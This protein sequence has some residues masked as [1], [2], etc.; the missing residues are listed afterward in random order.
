MLKQ[1]QCAIL[2]TGAVC[3][4][5]AAITSA[6]FIP[7]TTITPTAWF[8]VDSIAASNPSI[9]DGASVGSWAD[10]S[11]NG[12]TA[13]SAANRNPAYYA[14]QVNGHGSVRFNYLAPGT[15]QVN[16]AT[17]EYLAFTGLVGNTATS[18]LS[19]YVVANDT[20]TRTNTTA[21]A[22]G[23]LVNTRSAPTVNNGFAVNYVGQNATTAGYEHFGATSSQGTIQSTP[24]GED[25]YNLIAL[26]RTG[27]ASQL[28]TY[29]DIDQAGTSTT[30]SAFTPS[31]ATTTQIG[32]EGGSTGFY[33]FGDISE[34]III[35]SGANPLS[36]ADRTAITNYLGQKYA[37]TAAS[38]A[39]VPEPAAIATLTLGGFL[40]RRR[41]AV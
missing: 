18:N 32:T 34:I 41:R 40:I 4:A 1:S 21:T 8:D 25:N 19:I 10:S 14:N 33:F 12:K 9:V 31:T 3:S 20:G 5:S 26:N 7:T 16:S 23:P 22:R 37:I 29:T 30:W 6:A 28:R 17:N 13:T 27:L 39:V 35:D 2:L 36:D 38:T 24:M 11:G 15:T